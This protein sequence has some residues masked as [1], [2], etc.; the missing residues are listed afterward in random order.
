[1]ADA[2]HTAQAQTAAKTAKDCVFGGDDPHSSPCIL[3]EIDTIGT[4]S[5][6]Q[7]GQRGLG[8]HSHPGHYE[9]CLIHSG[10]PHWWVGD[11][12]V[13]IFPGEAYVTRPDE[14]HGGRNAMMDRCAISWLVVRIVAGCAGMSA[15]EARAINDA[16]TDLQPRTRTASALCQTSFRNLLELHQHQPAQAQLAAR[17]HLAL[18]LHEL[19]ACY[20]QAPLSND[21]PA[22]DPHQ[23]AKRQL[24]QF[25]AH[26]YSESIDVAAMA[27]CYQL[28]ET[29]FRAVLKQQ[30]GFSPHEY[31]L[32]FRLQRAQE[33]LGQSSY[34]ITDIAHQCGFSS[35]QYFA[36]ICKKMTGHTPKYWRNAGKT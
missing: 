26:N 21:E 8:A 2:T 5:Y 24:D 32:R 35:S 19:A 25:L 17:A 34:T 9:I 12:E 27:A 7:A 28:G 14:M 4:A 1:M 29:R 22:T 23:P 6:S 15:T 36:T 18:L 10:T 30:T 20:R 3:P 16:L 13:T 11:E 31:L 33:L